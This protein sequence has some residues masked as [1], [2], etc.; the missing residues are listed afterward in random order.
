MPIEPPDARPTPRWAATLLS[1]ANA[2]NRARGADPTYAMDDLIHAWNE[3][4]G[5]CAVSGMAFSLHIVGDGAARR[6]FAPSLDRIDRHQPY[7]RGNVRLVVAIANFAM[8]A[9][10]LPPLVELAAAVQSRHQHRPARPAGPPTDAPLDDMARIDA[11]FVATDAGILPFPPRSDM[12]DPLLQLLRAG[13]ASSREI[14]D[15][16]ARSFGITP[17][18]RAARLANGIPAWRNHVAWT[19]VDLGTHARGTGEIRRV[20]GVPAPDGGSMGLYV[21]SGAGRAR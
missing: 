16:L 21:L 4:G 8:N 17:A 12:H 19:L 13:Q 9:W 6:P 15:S 14:E 18:M 2:R 20:R 11:D 1:A 7:R 10:G 3:C 5:C